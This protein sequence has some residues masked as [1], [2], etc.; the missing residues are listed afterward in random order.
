MATA[1][2]WLPFGT[3]LQVRYRGRS[4]VV[5]VRDRFYGSGLDLTS[6]ACVA[7]LGTKGKCWT[8]TAQWRIVQ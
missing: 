2:R 8:V 4:V 6:A 1:H 5:V 3:R 7:L